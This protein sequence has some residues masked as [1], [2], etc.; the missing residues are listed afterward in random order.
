[1]RLRESGDNSWLVNHSTPKERNLPVT[2]RRL[3]K[4]ILLYITIKK[5]LA[6]SKNCVTIVLNKCYTIVFL[7]M[8]GKW[9]FIGGLLKDY[10]F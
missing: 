8:R 5:D 7:F 2:S 9:Q 3:T 6:R 10:Q 4:Y 1:M